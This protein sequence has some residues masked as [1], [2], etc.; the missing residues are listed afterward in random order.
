MSRMIAW[1]SS[2]AAS[3]VMTKLV[4]SE[5]SNAMVVQCD[6]GDSEDEDNRRFAAD[7]ARW[8]NAPIPAGIYV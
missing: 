6:L 4:L 7:C 1:F 8:F 3:A 5:N 2:G